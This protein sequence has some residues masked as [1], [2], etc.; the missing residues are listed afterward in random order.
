MK[1]DEYDSPCS[2]HK[3]MK[4]MPL[5]IILFLTSCHSDGS[6]NDRL[7]VAVAAN[8]QYA[9]Q[10]LLEEFTAETGIPARPIISSSGKLTSQIQQTFDCIFLN[11]RT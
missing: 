6:K 3:R 7:N 11:D 4:W 5:W 8:A 10:A 2:K 1:G 9:A